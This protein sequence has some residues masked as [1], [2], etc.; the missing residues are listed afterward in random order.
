MPFSVDAAQ[1]LVVF[2]HQSECGPGSGWVEDLGGAMLWTLRGENRL[3]GPWVGG[4]G[5][6]EGLGERLAD[7][8]RFRGPCHPDMGY[9]QARRIPRVSVFCTFSRQPRVI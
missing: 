6:S 8:S 2:G 4:E 5:A 7:N 1:V 9:S 3:R